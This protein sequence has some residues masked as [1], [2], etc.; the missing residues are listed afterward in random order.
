MMFIARFPR[1]PL[2]NQYITKLRIAIAIT[3]TIELTIS[4]VTNVS[5]VT[6]SQATVPQLFKITL[7]GT[8]GQMLVT[9]WAS[10]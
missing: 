9:N 5:S 8:S 1:N 4:V 6:R 3:I 2:H 10:Y 7:P